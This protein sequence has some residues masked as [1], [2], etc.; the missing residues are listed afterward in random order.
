MSQFDAIEK[1]FW[2]NGPSRNVWMIVD[3]AR[4]QKRIFRFLL[5]CHLEQSCLYSGPIAPALEMAAPYLLQLEHESQETRQ[6]IDLSWGNNWGVFL[7]SS[8]NMRNLRTHLR[9]FLMV[10]DASGR[11]MTFRYYDPNVLRIY[12]PTCTGEELR[13]VFGPIECFWTEN[14]KDMDQMLEFQNDAGT[15]IKRARPL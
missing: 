8:T 10:R 6:L 9:R 4:D 14:G 3:C 13:T 11:R 15:L 5:S 7:R 12:L 2:P 1:H